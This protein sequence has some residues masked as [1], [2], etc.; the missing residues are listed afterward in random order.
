M[1]E[2]LLSPASINKVQLKN[3]IIMAPMT[4]EHCH[5]FIPNDKVSDYYSR[6]ASGGISA[7]ITEAIGVCASGI[8]SNSLP[9]VTSNAVNIW[10]QIRIRAEKYDC[11]ILPQI[12]HKGGLNIGTSL[13]PCKSDYFDKSITI[14]DDKGIAEII[15]AFVNAAVAFNLAGFRG[16]EI[17]A[18]HGYLLDQFMWVRTNI[19]KDHY[20][21]R[22]Q[23]ATEI[24]K[25]I[26]ACVGSDLIISFRVSQWK[27]NAFDAQIAQSPQELEL[28]L[29]P[30]SDAGVDV[31]HASSRRFDQT[32]FD[33]KNAEK[34]NLAGWI[35]RIT[36]KQTITVG[37]IG[38][39]LVNDPVRTINHLERN[40]G[41]HY[42]FVAVGRGLLA[43]H[44]LVNI[45]K[46]RHFSKLIKFHPK[47]LAT[48][49]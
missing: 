34:M 13:A 5:N 48:A 40:L 32:E 33:I 27:V 12:W 41:N 28:L 23:I 24:I 22:S 10:D 25:N 37:G 4:R 15:A 14:L 30:I 46:N 2:Y 42:D 20:G 39:A 47:M 43:N 21:V 3:R 45:I 29:G 18:A 49:F 1:S 11:L 6:Y 26:R 9:L 17:H 7:I 8:D 38:D 19:R 36:G 44:D 31:F 16:I 35:K